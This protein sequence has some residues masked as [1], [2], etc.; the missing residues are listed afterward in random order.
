MNSDRPEN[1]KNTTRTDT[2]NC[3]VCRDLLANLERFY[4]ILEVAHNQSE[5]EWLTVDEI[6]KELKISKSIVYRLIHN[7]EIE[8]ID[9]V[10]SNSRM[11]QKGHYRI[12]RKS[13]NKYL[14]RKKVKLLP[15]I[16]SLQT[17]SRHF[18]KVKNHL[19]L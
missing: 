18:P 19:G 16:S 4:S 6:A 13:L 9:I 17:H 15:E 5:S 3:S 7:S 8:A 14:E 12:Q 1:L 11:P 2:D 10:D